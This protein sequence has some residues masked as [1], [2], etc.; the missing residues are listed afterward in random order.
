MMLVKIP[1]RVTMLIRATRRRVLPAAR[2]RIFLVAL[3]ALGTA[4]AGTA[5]DPKRVEID[6]VLIGMRFDPT[7]FTVEPGQEVELVVRA[8]PGGMVHNL[9]IVEPGALD[10]VASLAMELGRDGMTR[11]WVP[12]TDKVLYH[13]KVLNPGE[14]EI[15]RFTAPETEGIYPYVCTIPGHA[16]SMRGQMHVTR[17]AQE[18]AD[19]PSGG[20]G[21]DWAKRYQEMDTGPFYSGVIDLPDVGTVDKGLA[22]RVGDRQQATVHFDTDLLRMSAGWS[23]GFLTFHSENDAGIRNDPPPSAAGNIRFTGSAV[24]GWTTGETEEP[25]GSQGSTTR[26]RNFPGGVSPRG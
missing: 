26:W 25:A 24:A 9:L 21:P 18:Q 2:A 11:H 4:T 12:D 6:A 20:G 16:T 7:R 10:E 8:A 15:L 13:T 23:G 14:T 19:Q 22:I 17:D 5:A 3:V 1:Q